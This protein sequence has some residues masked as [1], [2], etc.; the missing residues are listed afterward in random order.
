MDLTNKTQVAMFEFSGLTD[1][2]ELVPF[3]FTFFLL[4]YTM[5]IVVNLG[6]LALVYTY[7]S[8]HTPM[9]YFLCSLSVVDIL[10]S[11]VV[12]PKMLVDFLFSQKSISFIGC[13]L[14]FYSFCALASTEAILLSTMS[15]DRYVAICHPLHYTLIMTKKRCLGLVLY[16]YSISFLQSI[17]Q[18]SCVFT[19]TFCGPNLVHHFYCD[20]PPLLKL[21]CSSN[22]HCDMVTTFLVAACGIYTLT[23]ICLSYSFIISSIL[24]MTSSKGRRKTFSTCSSHIIC[25]STFITSVF[26]VYLRSHSGTF[27]KVDK[28]ASVF[29]SVVT[30]MLN[31]L[32]YGLRSQDLKRTLAHAM[33]KC[34]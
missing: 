4:I 30:P 7:P 25:V 31:P 3:L 15:Y 14:Q 16:S 17:L 22:L 19:L 27:E 9:Y 2:N 18:T 12:T 21:S 11:S 26:F 13:A 8:L 23:T 29:Y 6:M 1:D 5:T 24:R 34:C 20:F 10:Y 28:V 32:I 33:K